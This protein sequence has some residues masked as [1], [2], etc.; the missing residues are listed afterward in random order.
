[1]PSL[2]SI[3]PLLSGSDRRARPTHAQSLAAIPPGFDRRARPIRTLLFASF[4]AAAMAAPVFVL[5]NGSWS[6][7]VVF[8]LSNAT[9]GNEVVVY[10]RDSEGRLS[11]RRSFATGGNGSGG[12]LGNQG[13][14]AL[15]DSGQWLLAVNAG[16]DSVSVF[17]RVGNH[18]L[19]TDVESSG[20]V[21]PVS[22]TIEDDIVYVLNAGSDDV[23]GF[24]LS[25]YGRLTPISGSR[26][27]L[28]SSGTAP[29]QVE[30][31]RDGDLLAVTEKATN[32]VLTFAVDGDGRLGPATITDSPSPTPFGFAFGRRDTLLVSEAVGGAAGAST[33]SSYRL[34]GA[35]AATVVSAAVPSG[36]SA[37]C[38]V[39]T[40]RDGRFAYVSNTASGNLST[41][42]ISSEGA[43]TLDAA[44]AADT[45]AGSGPTDMA[46]DRNSRFLYSLNPGN[47][48]IS[49]F[50]VQANGA[51]QLIEHEASGLASFATGLVAR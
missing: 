11:G 3:I 25:I 16:S 37:A 45:G 10:N 30:F 39:V 7:G 41:Y 36:Q 46:L 2:F 34:N 43:A 44:I 21:R 48:T 47:G 9:S 27:P 28:S 8:A 40:T 22:V 33:L 35:A 19:R 17:L 42:R 24:R 29:A 31:N 18:L 14:V 1:M 15:S 20:G 26:R 13:A 49:A 38:W 50:R 6:D 5:A 4:A 23:Q 51:L 12:G 32:K